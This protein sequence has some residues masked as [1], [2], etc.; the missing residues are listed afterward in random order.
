MF[1]KQQKECYKLAQS[2]GMIERDDVL[3]Q[4]LPDP[5]VLAGLWL[6]KMNSYT[7]IMIGSN[8]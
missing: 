5:P 2:G 7:A 3:I 6:Y 8:T 1:P 4:I